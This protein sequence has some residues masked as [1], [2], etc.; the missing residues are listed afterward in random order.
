MGKEKTL[1]RLLGKKNTVISECT[2]SYIHDEIGLF[3]P[4]DSIRGSSLINVSDRPSYMVLVSFDSNGSDVFHYKARV[5]SPGHCSSGIGTQHYYCIMIDADYFEKR[6][7]MYSDTV[8]V[9]DDRNF[10]ICSDIL[11]ALNTFAFESSKSMMNSDITLAAQTEIITHWLIRSIIG[12]TL[13][14][15]AI[16]DDYSVARA[17]HYIELHFAENITVS[18][19]AKLGCVSESTFN[20]RFKK[21]TGRTPIEYLIDIRIDRAK[22]LLRRKSLSVTD[23]AMRCGFG[24]G[25]HFTSS[26]VQKT[27][28]T[29]SEYRNKYL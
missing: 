2:D 20:R 28:V 18:A 7:L 21:E 17:Q 11:K 27:G 10:E 25:A 1:S 23:V 6:W 8:P 19:L 29:P 4:S 26:F 24:T 13:D 9:F 22:K 16:S 15:R 14:M 12:E 5:E 3:I